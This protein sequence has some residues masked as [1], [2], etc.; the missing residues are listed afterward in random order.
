M[1]RLASAVALPAVACFGSAAAPRAA[2]A[3][4]C[5]SQ[6][7]G[8]RAALGAAGFDAHA[9]HVAFAAPDAVDPALLAVAEVILGEPTS[10][11]PLLPGAT[12]LRWLQSTFVG[13]DA[14]LRLSARRDYTCTRLA[15]AVFG[16]DMAE[17]VALHALAIERGYLANAARQARAEWLGARD[18]AA[19]AATTA[20]G[21]GG[22][23]RRLPG[24]TLGVLGL[25]EIGAHVARVMG[26][27][28]LGMTVVGCRRAPRA[29]AAAASVSR[30][31]AI[32][33]LPAFLAACDY[34]VA[35]L[36][37]TDA[38]RGLLDGDALAA[39]VAGGARPSVLVN[40][41]R[42][43][44]LSEATVSRALDAG[45]LRHFVGDVFAEEPLPASSALWAD[46]RVTVT[47]HVA[48]VTRAEDVAGVF[49]ANYARYCAEGVAG[50]RPVFDW[51]RGY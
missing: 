48:A 20:I 27:A 17:Y 37:S 36:P 22:G 21:V 32:D 11:A 45:W 26:P 35:L 2:P 1:R 44:L 51:E 29:D 39:C 14:L 31:Y 16:P 43:T 19:A 38:T 15:G 3:V 47:P 7:P 18:P 46:A 41:G 5:L 23:F 49:A 13:N 33:E 50:L 42:G 12:R 24:L 28:G 9:P 34:V 40:A 4:L 6:I 10:L 30:E 25:G 8:L